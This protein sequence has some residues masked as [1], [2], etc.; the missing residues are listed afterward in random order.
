MDSCDWDCWIHIIF[1][2]HGPGN[3]LPADL[4]ELHQRIQ[5]LSEAE[6][7]QQKPELAVELLKGLH[8]AQQYDLIAQLGPHLDE[9]ISNTTT[10]HRMLLAQGAQFHARA[11]DQLGLSAE[12]TQMFDVAGQHF[13]AA[14]AHVKGA[15]I[16]HQ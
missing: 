9:I 10:K 8:G 4:E 16:S 11:L 14:G 1:P 3:P 2:P 5:S 6:L 7:K 15:A 13:M 12:A